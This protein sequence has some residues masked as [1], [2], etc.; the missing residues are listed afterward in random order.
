MKKLIVFVLMCTAL[1]NIQC[2]QQPIEEPV[3]HAGTTAALHPVAQ[4]AW[5]LTDP[6]QREAAMAAWEAKIL[7]LQAA[8]RLT[9]HSC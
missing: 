8:G 5:S 2:M 1:I 9:H 4:H 3:V 7:A 6:A